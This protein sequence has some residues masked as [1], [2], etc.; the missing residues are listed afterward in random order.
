MPIL[1]N[2]QIDHIENVTVLV[3][4]DIAFRHQIF[5]DGRVHIVISESDKTKNE[6]MVKLNDTEQLC[7]SDKTE[8]IDLLIDIP[9]KSGL[10]FLINYLT[11]LRS[12]L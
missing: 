11:E 3:L 9:E 6:V 5:E 4:K 12:K 7:W 2:I 10:D 8:H 1:K